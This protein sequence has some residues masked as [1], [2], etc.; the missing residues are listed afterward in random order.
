MVVKDKDVNT[1]IL[2]SVRNVNIYSAI[3]NT[4]LRCFSTWEQVCVVSPYLLQLLTQ[5]RS[6]A[7]SAWQVSPQ[8][9]CPISQAAASPPPQPLGQQLNIIL[10]L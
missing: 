4:V 9:Y 1:K 5:H 2:D 3:L 10:A 6:N 8:L 7:D